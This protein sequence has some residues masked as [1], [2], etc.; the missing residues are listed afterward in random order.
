MHQGTE[1]R[2]SRTIYFEPHKRLVAQYYTLERSSDAKLHRTPLP[3][4]PSAA[5]QSL[6]PSGT[7]NRSAAHFDK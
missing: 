2:H 5:L 6:D 3:A 1:T 4:D 7:R